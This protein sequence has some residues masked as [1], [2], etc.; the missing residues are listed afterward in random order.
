MLST[1]TLDVYLGFHA[2]HMGG[3]ETGKANIGRLRM[4]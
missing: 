2:V 3:N 1:Y 4:I